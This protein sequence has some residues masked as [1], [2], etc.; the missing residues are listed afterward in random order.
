MSA[1][2]LLR[3][4]CVSSVL[5]RRRSVPF[6]PVGAIMPSYA[7]CSS[8]R[9]AAS[10]PAACVLH[11]SSGPAAV[12]VL[13]WTNQPDFPLD[14]AWT[15]PLAH[16]SRERGSGEIDVIMGPMFAGKTTALLQRV[17]V[18][19]A[20]GQTVAVVKSSKDARYA[21]HW[22]VTHHG[23]CVRCFTALTLHEFKLKLGSAYGKFHVIAIDE[24]QFFPDLVDF[25]SHAADE[26]GKHVIIAGLTGDFQ[27]R[28]F[29]GVLDLVPLADTV[30]KLTS[31][32]FYCERDA[33]FSL[34][35]T[36]EEQQEVVGGLDKY[37]AVCRRCYVSPDAR[38]QFAAMQSDG[39]R[40]A[41]AAALVDTTG[42]PPET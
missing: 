4:R 27:R 29:G 10:T 5:L 8:P 11:D 20:A 30:T 33:H 23:R 41:A 1:L 31:Q 9:R 14:L 13:D 22:V 2:W 3:S 19:D 12:Q 32:C 6:V 36:A 42:C 21:Q 18:A 38:K 16:Q 24:A 40:G 17:A 34:R 7:C 28:P 25:C 37:R 15:E 39:S 26:D 35:V